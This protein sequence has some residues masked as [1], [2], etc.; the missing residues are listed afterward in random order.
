MGNFRSQRDSKICL[1]R[2]RALI[3]LSGV[4]YKSIVEQGRGRAVLIETLCHFATLAT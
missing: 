3:G 2:M 4:R 1:M